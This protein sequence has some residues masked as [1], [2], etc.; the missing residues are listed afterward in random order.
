MALWTADHGALS[1]R[2][3]FELAARA[4]RCFRRL[5]LRTGDHALLLLPPGPTLF[6]ATLALA[7]M[8]VTAVLVEPWMP[9]ARIDRAIELVRPR[10]FL[11]GLLGKLW[12]L[13]VP[14]IRRIPH[15]VSERDIRRADGGQFVL[16]DLPPETAASVAFSSGTTGQPKGIVRRHGYLWDLHDILAADE[17]VHG[18]T[19]PD[20]AVFAN[21]VLLHLSTGRG[22]LWVP[23]RWSRRDLLRVSAA[24]SELRPETMSCGPAFLARLLGESGVRLDS[25]RSVYVG[26]ALTDCALFESAFQRWPG[27][28][29]TQVY[30]GT[31]AEPVALG[32]ARKAVAA[33]RE[34]GLHQALSLGAPIPEIEAN[35]EPDTV[36]VSGPNVC[37]EYLGAPGETAAHKRRDSDGRLWHDM[38][39]RILA[40]QAGWWYQGRSHQPRAD[41]Q[42]EQDI[43]RELGSSAAFVHRRRNGEL[44]LLG[45][46]LAARAAKLRAG[47]PHLAGVAE[48]TIV[49]DR[50]H[51]ARIDR[52]A[53]LKNGAPW[54]AG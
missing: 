29:F 19:G 5:R 21:L 25:L 1:Y 36:W 27:V 22:S 54:L 46:K 11:A 49:R 52:A 51:R 33:S 43:Y 8:G 17:K 47:F 13:R 37:G 30:G 14:A 53:S 12:G 18:Y 3:L 24:G 35:I 39:D 34:R 7:G 32:D 48:L 41:F 40:D 28:R 38:G 6:A 20:V 42:L 45:E 16:E 44:W 9:V 2:E 23:P 50:R 10:L 4:Q 31:E 15:W 26:G